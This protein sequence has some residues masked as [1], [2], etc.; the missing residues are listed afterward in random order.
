M[1]YPS[2]ADDALLGTLRGVSAGSSRAKLVLACALGAFLAHT[3]MG[4]AK[5]GAEVDRSFAGDGTLATSLP[6][7]VTDAALDSQGRIVVGGIRSGQPSV[8]RLLPDGSP[9]PSFG[10]DGESHEASVTGTREVEIEVQPDDSIRTLALAETGEDKYLR[11]DFNALGVQTGAVRF[12]GSGGAAG[13]TPEGGVVATRLELTNSKPSDTTF[14]ETRRPNSIR[15]ASP[16][17]S[18]LQWPVAITT[19]PPNS[20]SVRAGPSSKSWTRCTPTPRAM[21]RSRSSPSRLAPLPSNRR[22]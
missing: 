16:R 8:A 12:D 21:A 19:F 22:R 20:L 17:A 5:P 6:I 7:E 18:A 10:G 13:L 9:D 11:I 14:S 1:R 15:K 3:S 2:V 4:F